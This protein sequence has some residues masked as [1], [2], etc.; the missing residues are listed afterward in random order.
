MA[1]DSGPSDTSLAVTTSDTAAQP[2]G[3]GLFVGTGGNIT[4]RLAG[5]GTTDTVFKGI[6]AGT[7]LPLRFKLIKTATTAADMVILF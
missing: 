5:D 2:L 1:I 4:G 3:R 6:A 7:I